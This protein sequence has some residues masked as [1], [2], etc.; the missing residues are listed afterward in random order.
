MG[1]RTIA[2][3]VIVLLIVVAGGIGIY[4]YWSQGEE[5]KD[6]IEVSGNI[7]ATEINV[8]AEMAGKVAELKVDEGEEVE[9]GE[10]LGKLDDALLKAQY[11]QAKASL[12]LAKVRPDPL[13]L[14]QAQATFNLAEVSLKKATLTAPIAG[15]VVSRPL[16]VGEVV[17]PGTTVFVIANLDR[18]SLVVYIPEAD[19]GKVKLGKEAKITVDSFPDRTFSGTIK[20]ISS[21]AEFTPANV[22][23]KEQRVNL[24]FAVTISIENKDHALK[25]GMPADA[26]I[27]T[28]RLD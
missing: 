3:V 18:V 25:P 14:A 12:D 10:E 28:P 24:V 26:E 23:T 11:D 17:A 20:H 4:Y 27:A 22:Q 19:L 21:Q 15:T 5:E 13:S 9:E 6:V 8:G 7:E 2:I 1:K 16:E